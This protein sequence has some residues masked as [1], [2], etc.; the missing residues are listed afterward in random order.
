MTD[1][2]DHTTPTLGIAQIAPQWPYERLEA[3]HTQLCED[4]R[5]TMR[6]KNHD[7]SNG[8]ESSVGIFGNLALCELVGQCSVAQGI[9]IRLGDKFSR[10]NTLASKP[11][12]VKEESVRDTVE[13]SINY[14]IL[15]LAAMNIAEE[16]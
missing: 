10:L 4:A 11:A 6:R 12:Q 14:L 2:T 15:F 5:E 16:V 7:Y 1:S 3:L 8:A 9:L 13:D